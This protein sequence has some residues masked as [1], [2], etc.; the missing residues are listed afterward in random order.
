MGL[1]G[2]IDGWPP[3]FLDAV[4]AKGHRVLVFDNEGVGRSTLRPGR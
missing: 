4:A 2:T 3:S 1:S